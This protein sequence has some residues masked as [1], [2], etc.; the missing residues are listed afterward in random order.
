MIVIQIP[1]I[2]FNYDLFAKVIP[3]HCVSYPDLYLFITL[4][5]NIPYNL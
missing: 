1:I 4:I 3:V 2:L 5:N